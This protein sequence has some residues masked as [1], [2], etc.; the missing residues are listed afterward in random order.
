MTWSIFSAYIRL[1]GGC[2]DIFHLSGGY[3]LADMFVDICGP[4]IIRQADADQRQIR[5]VTSMSETVVSI[6]H[7]KEK[8]C[9]L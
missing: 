9:D 7:E 4:W 6:S 5:I 8:Q 3:S 2:T 1:V